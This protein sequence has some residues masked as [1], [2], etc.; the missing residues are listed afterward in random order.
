MWCCDRQRKWIELLLK[1]SIKCNQDSDDSHSRLD[2]DPP[3]MPPRKSDAASRKS[4]AG[5]EAATATASSAAAEP[6]QARPPTANASQA[7]ASQAD[8]SQLAEAETETADDAADTAD[9]TA[10][11]ASGKDKDA[12]SKSSHHSDAVS[13]EDL[14]MPRSIVT[15]LTKGMLPPTTQ[16]QGSAITAMTKSATVFI[17]HLANAAN[18][19]TT[20]AG[21]KTIT[22]ADVFAA[23]DDIEFGFMKEQLEAEFA[24]MSCLRFTLYAV[25][26]TYATGTVLMD[27]IQPNTD[28]ETDRLP[29]A[30][31]GGQEGPGRSGRGRRGG[32]RGRQGRRSAC[33]T[34]SGS[35]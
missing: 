35:T 8:D 7:D 10:P 12:K 27:R 28:V 22:P 11:P 29:E 9:T 13:I 19:L 18:T 24:S 17:S 14:N 6:E 4:N 20:N 23:L 2:G 21:K 16:L 25:Y 3:N 32:S 30:G 33:R 1:H 34:S 31:G 26:T 5:A 15:R